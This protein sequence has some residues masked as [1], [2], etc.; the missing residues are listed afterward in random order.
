M[1][2]RIW[3][4]FRHPHTR[5]KRGVVVE[6]SETYKNRK[7]FLLLNLLQVAKLELVAHQLSRSSF[8]FSKV[9]TENFESTLFESPSKLCF[10][11]VVAIE[12][13]IF[14]SE[15]FKNDFKN[16]YKPADDSFLLLEAVQNDAELIK[17]QK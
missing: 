15:V 3:H 13:A 10:K 14:N 12:T 8:L 6:K 16:V 5:W 7:L 11:M 4:K 9:Q 1:T 2:S 17:K